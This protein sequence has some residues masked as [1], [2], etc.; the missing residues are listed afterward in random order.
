MPAPTYPADVMDVPDFSPLEVETYFVEPV[1]TDIQVFYAIPAEGWMSWFGAFKLGLP[2]DP[3]DSV[4]GLSILNVT[5]VAH[6]GCTGHFS[7]IPPVGP[8]VDDM[9][10]ALA[11]LSPFVLTKPPAAVTAY[12]FS[13]KHL[14][15]TVPDLAFERSDDGNTFTDCSDGELWSWIGAPLSFAYHG[16]SHPGQV[17]EFWLLDVRGQRLMIVAGRSPGSS[18]ADI[19]ELR[20]ILDSIDIVP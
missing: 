13:G 6:D 11:A 20:A 19:A 5:N 14:E 2:T 1:G 16:Y 7:A 15:L 10:T 18:E 12:G 8:T 9:A 17:E 4:V 3:P